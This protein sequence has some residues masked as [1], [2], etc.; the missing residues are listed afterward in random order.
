MEGEVV[1]NCPKFLDKRLVGLFAAEFSLTD[2]TDE[3]AKCY[4][5]L[6]RTQHSRL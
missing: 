1:E 2:D 6:F 4:I 5:K 3:T